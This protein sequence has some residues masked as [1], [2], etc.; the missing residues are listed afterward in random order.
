[1]LATTSCVTARPPAKV[2]GELECIGA[3]TSRPTVILEAGAFG[4]AADWSLV[5]EKLATKQRV[6]A[7]DRDGIGWAAIHDLDRSPLAIAKRLGVLVAAHEGDAPVILAG[8]SNGGLYVEAFARM[9]PERTAGLVLVDAVGTEVKDHPLAVADLEHEARLA[10]F[11]PFARAVGLTHLVPLMDDISPAAEAAARRRSAWTGRSSILAGLEEERAFLP[12][13]ADV[14][15]LP[16]LRPTI[17]VAVIV[18]SRTPNAP[19][20]RDWRAAQVAPA[21]RAC[22]AV[23]IDAFAS[24]TSILDAQRDY[25]VDA[26][27]WLNGEQASVGTRRC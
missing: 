23:V 18:A 12:G 9:W 1:M 20:D 25:V 27:G 24:H 6:C 3:R 7:Y 11:T 2:S 4:G 17:P 5:A 19:L 22:R 8:H 21:D 13:L 15:A 16:A 14:D 10:A 26:V